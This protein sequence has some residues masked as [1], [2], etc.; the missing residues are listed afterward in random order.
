MANARTNAALLLTIAALSQTGFPAAARGAEPDEKLIAWVQK[1]VQDAQP[2]R[3]ERK[4]DQVGWA[5]D[6]RD[7]ERLAK[8]H[9]RPIFLFTHD[10]RVNLGRC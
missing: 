6:I 2:T 10:G 7:A 9:Q 8:I 5:K 4:F 1:Q 3:S